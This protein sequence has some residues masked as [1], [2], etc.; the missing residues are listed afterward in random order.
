MALEAVREVDGRLTFQEQMRLTELPD[1][2]RKGA[3]VKRYMSRRAAWM[4]GIDLPISEDATGPRRP[5]P[6]RGVAAYGAHVYSQAG[7]AAS[8]AFHHFTEREAGNASRKQLGIHV[9]VKNQLAGLPPVSNAVLDH[10]AGCPT[11]FRSLLSFLSD[12]L[13]HIKAR[14]LLV[15]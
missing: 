11:C 6:F 12:H 3:V 8:R 1:V 13:H 14:E 15:E 10:N 4:P 7:L 9:S 2:I 5:V